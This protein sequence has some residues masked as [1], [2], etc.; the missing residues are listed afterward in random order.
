MVCWDVGNALCELGRVFRSWDSVCV[1]R[2]VRQFCSICMIRH[3]CS[4]KNMI[5]SKLLRT[6]YSCFAIFKQFTM[7]AVSNP[8]LCET[9]QI[10]RSFRCMGSSWRCCLRHSWEGLAIFVSAVVSC[11]FSVS[12]SSFSRLGK[13]CG[14]GPKSYALVS[15]RHYD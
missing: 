6:A 10:F 11:Q 5:V 3:D 14:R 12:F 1:C 2:R 7:F 13:E 8:A 15:Q 4:E 9:F